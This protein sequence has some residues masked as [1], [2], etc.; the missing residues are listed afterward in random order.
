VESAR[1]YGNLA[2]GLADLG[3]LELSWEMVVQARVRAERFGLDDWLLWLRG[4]AAYP[5]YYSGDWDEALQI[6]DELI[7]EFREHPFWMEM[8]CRGLRG[9]IRLARGDDA[10]AREDAERALELSRAAKDPQVVFPSLSLC[11][12]IV[13]SADPER[14]SGFIAEILKEW[15]ARGWPSA[16]EMTWMTDVAIVVSQAGRQTEF[17]DTVARAPAHPS[18]WRRAAVAYASGDLAG[19]ARIYAEIGSG[20]DQA[21][22]RLRAADVYLRDGRRAEADVELQEALAFWRKAG[23]TA[24]RREGEALLAAA[25]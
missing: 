19:A 10:G 14:A 21:Y 18:V 13:A 23:A 12:R 15:E 1:A 9:Q 8:P 17:L 5:L 24:Y 3:E 11:A 16:S 7:E 22:A 4:E 2:S 25:S 20:P 6:L